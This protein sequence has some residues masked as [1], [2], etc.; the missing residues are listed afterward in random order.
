[1]AALARR[2]HLITPISDGGPPTGRCRLGGT[3]LLDPGT[4]WPEVDGIPLSLLAVLDVDALAPWLGEELHTSPGLLNFFHVQPYLDYEQYDGIN[5]FDDP[6][7]WRVIAAKPERAVETPAPAS[8]FVFDQ[9]PA[10]ADP[11]ITL[12]GHEESVVGSLDLGPGYE[13]RNSVVEAYDIHTTWPP[14]TDGYADGHRAFGWPWPQQGA[15]TGEDE[16]L[17]LQ[18]SSD[19]EFQWGDGGL[20]YYMITAEALRAGDFSQVRVQQGE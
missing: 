17:L 11:I 20:L 14:G 13:Q 7:A 8:A 10:W 2:G 19:D 1:M 4:H 6:R 3:A 15:L 12:P 16:V 5:P 9:R 18:L